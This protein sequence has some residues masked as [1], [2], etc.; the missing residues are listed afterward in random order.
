MKNLFLLFVF[1]FAAYSCTNQNNKIEKSLS[2]SVKADTGEAQAKGFVFNDE[3]ENGIM[4]ASENG[5]AGVFVSNGTDI[6]QTNAQGVYEIP[7]SDDA[8]IFVIKPKDW[9]T[10]VNDD[11]LPQFYYIHK[12]SGSPGNFI[13]KGVAPTGK[14]PETI[15]FPLYSISGP[16]DFK[17][18]VF[19]DPQPYSIEEVDFLTEDVI[20][21]LI[22]RD[23]LEFGMTMGDIVG[24]DL[25]LFSPLNQAVSQIGIPWYNVLGNHDINYMAPNDPLSDD[26]YESVYGPATY[27]FVYGDVH[28]IVVDD[29]I[30]D[31]VPGSTKYVGGLRPDQFEF[32]SNYLSVVPKEDLIVLTMHI[33]LAQHGN[34]FRQSDQKKLFDLLKDFPNTLSISAHTHV[35][36]NRFFHEGSSDWQQ[37]TPHHHFNVGTTSGSWWNG[38][39]SET[40]VPHTMMRDGTPNGYSFISFRGNEYI[41]DWKVAGSPDDHKMNIHVPRG[42]VAGSSDTTLLTVNFFNG[43]EES[44]LQYRI[45]GQ[46]EWETME[47]TDKYDPYY[48]MIS[49]RWE[50][51]QKLNL[52]ELW[53]KNPELENEPFPGSNMP[54]PQK[55]THIWEANIGTDWPVGRHVIEV[56]AN[57]RYGRS[58]TAYHTM[59]VV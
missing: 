40:D 18:V 57:D 44:A 19:G 48:L 23:D 13:Y 42:I 59:R 58:F 50:N 34:T 43:S 2:H 51:F 52:Q 46:T 30:H 5:I 9:M 12:P 3:N 39:R 29:V 24:D 25:D 31:S 15:N 35:H 41:I 1:L 49:R 56:K 11:N 17:M 37:A 38:M 28:F 14:L 45:K 53:N 21:E 54:R 6:V 32:V 16:D 22:G 20:T 4:D 8:I 26:T 47:K 7:A 33:P 10:P 27:A 36:D 55:S